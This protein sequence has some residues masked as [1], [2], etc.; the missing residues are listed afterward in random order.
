M[1]LPT[2]CITPAH[3]EDV[4]RQSVKELVRDHDR[5][6]ILTRR[7]LG[8]VVPPLRLDRAKADRRKLALLLLAQR[9]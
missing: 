9:L 7:H 6:L 5:E 1:G 8:D 2:L 3:L 4:D